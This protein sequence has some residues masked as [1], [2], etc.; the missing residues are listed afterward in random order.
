MSFYRTV[1]FG[2]KGF[3]EYTRSGYEAAAKKFNPTDTD[4]DMSDQHIMITGANSGIGKIAALECAK[5][6]AHVYMVCRDE[7]RGKEA[8]EEI[9]RESN[10]RHVELHLCDMSKPQDVFAFTKQFVDSKKPL[11]VLCNNSGCMI[12]ERQMI[13]DEHEANFATNT[14]GT[15]ILTKNLVPVLL[16][17]QPARVFTTSSGG[18]YNVKLDPDDFNSTQ[19]RTFS[20]DLVYAQNKRQQVVMTERLAVRHPSIFF[21]SWHPGWADTPAVRSSMPSFHSKVQNRLRTPEQGADTLVWLCC[22]KDI[23][24][25]FKNGDFFQDRAPVSKHLPLA[26]TKSTVDEEERFMRNL[27]RVYEKY[28]K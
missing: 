25:K 26:W 9:I 7:K 22:L 20:G 6:H 24:E 2:I 1:A 10:N 18:M 3:T 4:V 8:Q 19:M 16:E 21:A 11:N 15:Y 14:L 27:D 17:N 12:N 23:A 28:V 5:R 13:N